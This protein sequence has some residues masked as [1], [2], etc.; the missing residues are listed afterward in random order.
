MNIIDLTRRYTVEWM[1]TC[2]VTSEVSLDQSE[3]TCV[4]LFGT[5]VWIVNIQAV[6]KAVHTFVGTKCKISSSCLR[7]STVDLAHLTCD[8][9][10]GRS[11]KVKSVIIHNCEHCVIETTPRSL[12]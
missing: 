10:T 7:I 4:N 11:S 3:Y 9:V 2:D 12:K 8:D 1:M 6:M 5:A